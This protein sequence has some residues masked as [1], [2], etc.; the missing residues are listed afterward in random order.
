M[1][2]NK[3]TSQ[4]Q[5]IFGQVFELL[6]KLKFVWNLNIQSVDQI[7]FWEN[8]T[9]FEIWH[10]KFWSNELLGKLKFEDKMLGHSKHI[11]LVKYLVENYIKELDDHFN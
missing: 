7:S 5:K 6:R 9:L 4:K 10:K 2:K 8:L 11:K 1:A 3:T